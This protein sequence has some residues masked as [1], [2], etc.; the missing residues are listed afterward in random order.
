MR[1]K[2]IFSSI[3]ILLTLLLLPGVTKAQEAKEVLDKM[4]YSVGKLKSLT[5]STKISERVNGTLESGVNHV[6]VNFKPYKAYL[7]VT[8]AEI[9]YVEGENN[10]KALVRSNSLPFINLSLD[11]LGSVMRKGQHHT[12]FELGFSYFADIINEAY[13]TV[14]NDFD[15][16]F[17]FKGSIKYEGNDCYVIVMEHPDFKFI[18]YEV[19]KGEDL[20]KIA[21]TRRIS[22]YMILERNPE[23]KDYYSVSPG[24]KIMIPNAY[25]QKTIIY[26]DKATYL[27]IVQ[28]VYDDKG[29]FARY[30]FQNVKINPVFAEDE[31]TKD[32]EDYNF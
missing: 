29:I 8:T 21:K 20:I 31:F 13:K 16:Y 10:N 27:P 17:T 18:P 15:K 9:L 5:Y 3:F 7:K 1:Q 19:K 32:F 28:V 23:I 30:E 14:G 2:A 6:K 26:I 24:Q 11:P 4:I 22:D 12:I 25:A